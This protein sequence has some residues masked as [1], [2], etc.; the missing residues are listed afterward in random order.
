MV[1]MVHVH[2]PGAD[3]N[4]LCMNVKSDTN[5]QSF[6]LIRQQC[7]KSKGQDN[8]LVGL[9]EPQLCDFSHRFAF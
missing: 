1:S 5:S 8:A 2:I 7:R 6:M 4:T 3:K 9:R